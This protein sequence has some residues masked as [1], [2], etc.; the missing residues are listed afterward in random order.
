MYLN[1]YYFVIINCLLASAKTRFDEVQLE[2]GTNIGEHVKSRILSLLRATGTEIRVERSANARNEN[3]NVLILA[4]GN[5]TYC[6]AEITHSQVQSLPP[7]GFK[8]VYKQI[9]HHTFLLATNGRS[10]NHD[11]HRNITFNKDKIHY[12]AVVGAYNALELI[13]FSFLHPLSPYVPSSV[14]IEDQFFEKSE[15]PYWPSRIFH[16]HTQH[17][18]EVTEVLQGMD[19]PMFGPHGPHCHNLYHKNIR[20]MSASSSKS[21][22]SSTSSGSTYCERWEDMV[23]DVNR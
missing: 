5:S 8:T 13:G 6:L 17:P 16:I 10:L 2:I 20:N 4:I 21:T 14:M 15:C 19:I 22:S 3:K 11:T 9:S 18:L 12:G 1:F 7:E 23:E